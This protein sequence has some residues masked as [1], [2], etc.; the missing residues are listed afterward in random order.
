[1]IW[2]LD[3]IWRLDFLL[4]VQ[5]FVLHKLGIAVAKFCPNFR[6]DRTSKRDT[7]KT[8]RK[9]VRAN[10]R[11]LS[12]AAQAHAKEELEYDKDFYKWANNQA[13]FLRKQEF[14]KLDIDNLIE[15]IESLG[16]SEKRTLK[17]YLEILLMHKLKVDFQPKKHTKSWDASIKEANYKA[18]ITLEENPSLKPKLR[19]ILK[20]AYF[21]ARL[22]AVVE[23]GLSENTFP[24]EC[25]WSLKDIFPDLEKKYY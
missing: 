24:E 23:T 14:S 11:R 16:R 3:K 13:K 22:K 5:N 20:D 17:S 18:K 1:M 8:T 6:Y 4:S 21:S 7:M 15:E 25:P 10:P 12:I 2:S 9:I 19:D